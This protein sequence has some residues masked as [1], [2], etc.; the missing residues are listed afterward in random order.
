MVTLFIPICRTAYLTLASETGA[1]VEIRAVLP[2]PNRK[3]PNQ[4]KV[5]LYWFYGI[6]QQSSL[7]RGLFKYN[8][9]YYSVLGSRISI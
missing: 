4:S 3:E 5:G 7:A 9:V 2:I 1:G 8:T 6:M